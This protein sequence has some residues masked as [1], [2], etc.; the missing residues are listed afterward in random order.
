V[1]VRPI[2]AELGSGTAVMLSSGVEMTA[3][4]DASGALNI[5]NSGN[6]SMITV[7]FNEQ[8]Q[9][10]RLEGSVDVIKIDIKPG[11]YSNSIKLKSK[12]V[13]PLAVLSS[14]EF[15]AMKVDPDTVI[16][17]WA[18]PVKWKIRCRR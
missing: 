13:K 11:I 14:D 17:T 10:L 8:T 18:E 7:E 12:N 3:T 15:N 4:E 9:D 6:Q 16:F 2:L 1:G 5:K